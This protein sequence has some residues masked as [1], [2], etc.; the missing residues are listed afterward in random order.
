[1]SIKK[2]M[3][4]ACVGAVAIAAPFIAKHEGVSLTAYNDPVR[5]PTICYGYT[6][7]V[8]LGDTATPDQC[9]YLLKTETYKY[10]AAVDKYITAQMPDTRR[11]ALTSFA[12]NVGIENFKNST[13]RKKMNA[14]DTRGACDELLRWVYAKGKRLRGLERRRH[15]ERDLCLKGISGQ[16]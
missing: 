13:L 7:N 10:L 3:M 16:I 6:H 5:I 1:M 8:K 9:A 2:A 11:A 15:N 4:G 14:G 12:Y